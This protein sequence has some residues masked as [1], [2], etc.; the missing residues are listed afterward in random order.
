MIHPLNI[1]TSPSSAEL[2]LISNLIIQELSEL[3]G[4]IDRM[5]PQHPVHSVLNIWHNEFLNALNYPITQVVKGRFL[6]QILLI[7]ENP[8]D[9]ERPFHS[10]LFSDSP[11]PAIRFLVRKMIDPNSQ[12]FSQR[13]FDAAPRAQIEEMQRA[14]LTEQMH[15]LRAIQKERAQERA[16]M[17]AGAD[18]I[19]A[20]RDRLQV[21]RQGQAGMFEAQVARIQDQAT[22]LQQ[23]IDEARKSFQNREADLKRA[24][25]D[26]ETELT[27]LGHAA[28]D[29]RRD[30]ETARRQG[31]HL[32][33]EAIAIQQSLN[34]TEQAIREKQ[35]NLLQ[36]ILVQA[37]LLVV[38]YVIYSC[39]GYPI[40]L[41]NPE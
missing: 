26:L 4:E 15:R 22:V 24:Q 13:F 3:K 10:S 17:T 7:F 23:E 33:A 32:R 29:L 16:Q 8:L 28:E 20:L 38:S 39:T 1:A 40:L 35:S 12:F 6:D 30:Y 41:I 31:D 27:Q 36:K 9:R 11:P 14:R 19:Q 2:P 37:A 5:D 25:R 21:R 34:R 18:D